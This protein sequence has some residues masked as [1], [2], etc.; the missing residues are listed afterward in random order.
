[1]SG[2]VNWRQAEVLTDRYIAVMLGDLGTT[3]LLMAQVPLIGGLICLSWREATPDS[4][5]YF[6]LCLAAVFVG[7]MNACREIVKERPLYARERMV[8]LEIPAYVIS[9]AQVLC[10][11]NALQCAILLWMVVQWVGLPGVKLMLFLTL[12]AG[13]MTGTV[14]GLCISAV[15]SSSDQ[16]MALAPVALIPQII[17]T[18]MILP[19]GSSHGVV[20]WI[21]RLNP[22]RWTHEL[23][24]KVADFAREPAW[25]DC[26]QDAGILLAFI[27]V[28][29]VGA[30]G[31]LWMQEG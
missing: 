13:A 12:L 25:S 17:F 30:M 19:E 15:V 7:C 26:F 3:L 28:L 16:A 23:Y 10:G 21:E 14:V 2:F 11:L 1:M 22:L 31:I 8:N 9:K 24:E 5:L 20:E 29:L 6:C 4:K 27:G 18:K